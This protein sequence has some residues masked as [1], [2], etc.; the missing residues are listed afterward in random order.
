MSRR[1]ALRCGAALAATGLTGCPAKAPPQPPPKAAA[2]QPL[3]LLV[4]DDPALGQAIAREWLGR[5]EEALTV[6]NISAAELATASRLPGDLV[7]FAGGLIGHLAEQNLILPFENE[8]LESPDFKLRDIF[9]LVRLREMRWGQRTLAV[10]LGSPQLLLAYRADVF[11]HLNLE[12]PADW[13]AYQQAIAQ[14]GD[15]TKLGDLAFAADQ[16]WQPA[17]EP[18]AEGWAGQLLLARAAAYA[19]HRD[20]I[21]PLFRFDT[22]APLIADPP[23][24][25]A[26][27]E[28][29]AAAQGAGFSQRRLAPAEA[30]TELRLG[31]CAMALAWPPP[32]LPEA[33]SNFDAQLA[34]TLLPGS[35][36]VYRSATRV[37]EQRTSDQSPHVPLLSTWGR[38]A[39]VCAGS[40]DPRRAQGFAMWLAGRE[41]SASV[42]ARSAATTLFRNSQIVS[43][44][45]WTG[46]L[47]PNQSRQYAEVLGQT[48]ILTQAFP[49]LTLPGRLDYLATLD[50]AVYSALAGQSAAESL[51]A[52]AKRW[53]EITEQFGAD[54]QKRAN[55]RSLGQ[56]DV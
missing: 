34:F 9:D 49:G 51:A 16:P 5:T 33:K 20:H 24:V 44:G 55:G 3:V 15:R 43:S 12:P 17:S 53:Q 4:A 21:S 46:P 41:A 56:V 37:W 42:A 14:L 39:A 27:R 50:Q 38:M 47:P 54:Q 40:S 19:L 23:F 48:L 11:Q 30:F 8:T 31:R 28:L 29:V 13:A 6:R 18:L 1:T 32:N 25:R 10:P 52:A 22:L 45:R 35:S 7:V 2:T 26:L 36:E